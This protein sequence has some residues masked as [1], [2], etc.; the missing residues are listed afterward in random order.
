MKN[1]VKKIVFLLMLALSACK[2]VGPDYKRTETKLPEK[3]SETELSVSAD[4]D[5]LKQWWTHY[6][7][8][9]LNVLVEYTLSTTGGLLDTFRI[10]IFT[11]STCS[12]QEQ[13]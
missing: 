10:T 13:C 12:E 5:V 8:A 2:T 1:I 9:K 11:V 4:K 7:D 6:Q 3:F